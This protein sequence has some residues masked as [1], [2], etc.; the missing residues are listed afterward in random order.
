MSGDKLSPGPVAY[1]VWM[2][3]VHVVESHQEHHQGARS[4]LGSARR[5]T[6]SGLRLHFEQGANFPQR[7]L[8]V[9]G[10]QFVHFRVAPRHRMHFDGELTQER[11]GGVGEARRHLGQ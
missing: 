3:R 9:G 1:Q 8:G 7:R 4:K 2:Q 5:R 11:E 6:D 10:E